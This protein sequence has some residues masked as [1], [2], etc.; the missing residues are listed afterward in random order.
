M[1]ILVLSYDLKEVGEQSLR[2]K[3]QHE[4]SAATETQATQE[5]RVE[6]IHCNGTVRLQTRI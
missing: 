5:N 2:R 1:N 4:C 3:G 6:K